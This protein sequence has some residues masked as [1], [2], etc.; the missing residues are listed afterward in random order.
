[1]RR[2]TEPTSK[3]NQVLGAT[4]LSRTKVRIYNDT[5]TM[6]SNLADR[7]KL[8]VKPR[9]IRN[10]QHMKMRSAKSALTNNMKRSIVSSLN[11]HRRRNELKESRWVES[12]VM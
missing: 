4:I 9:Y 3:T 6:I 8:Q 5:I 10:R 12:C 11:R 7:K 2:I 1:M